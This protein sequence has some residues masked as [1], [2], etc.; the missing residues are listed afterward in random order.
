MNQSRHLQLFIGLAVALLCFSGP[1]ATKVQHM[2]LQDLVERSALIF[3]GTVVDIVPGTVEAGGGQIPTTTYRIRVEEGFRGVPDKGVPLVD[4]TMV[5][6]VKVQKPE[7]AIRR[8]ALFDD[9]PRL[10]VGGDYLLFTTAPSSAGLSI[11]V[12]INAE[13]IDHARGNVRRQK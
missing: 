12:E 10:K 1:L 2:N 4:I 5:G 11:T 9:V 8:L 6:S 7:G 13:I 3:R